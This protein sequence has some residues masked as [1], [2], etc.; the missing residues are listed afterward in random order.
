MNNPLK[1][2]V[3]S[4]YYSPKINPIA[5]KAYSALHPPPYHRPNMEFDY[6]VWLG[7]SSFFSKDGR[8]IGE[9][10]TA[11]ERYKVVIDTEFRPCKFEGTRYG[12]LTN[13]TAS[14]HVLAEIQNAIQL[15]T[16]LRNHYMQRRGLQGERMNLLQSYVFSK[17]GAALTAFHARRRDNRIESGSLAP[18]ETAFFTL[19]VGP[20]MV[21][22]ALMEMGSLIPLDPEPKSAEELYELADSSRSLIS[23]DGTR[24]CA[25]SKKLIIQFADVVWNGSFKGELK[26]PEALRV[27]NSVDDWDGFYAYVYASSK[28]E[29]MIK[30]HQALCSQALILL[31]DHPELC[32]A[33][34]R[35]WVEDA[36][37]HF[38]V[39]LGRGAEGR[40]LL[41][42][43]IRVLVALMDE[44][45]APQIRSELQAAGLI[46]ADGS[47]LDRAQAV[48]AGPRQTAARVLARSGE[49]L[50][51]HCQQELSAVHAA[52]NRFQDSQISLSDL[53]Q[54]CNGPQVEPLMAALRA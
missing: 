1:S 37:S 3:K 35:E 27:F 52:L 8:Q 51:P 10:N 14:R 53:Y 34:E 54:R 23:N 33:Q 12:L 40:E 26:S 13:I 18:L 41:N 29:L 31:H 4:A 32:S 45:D 21:V 20:F 42:N 50:Y 39:S 24:G 49:V 22:R 7:I 5:V 9:A 15:A 17:M 47:G 36:L 44:H 30:L 46:A 16:L 43:M 25:G 6:D 28:L 38:T 11:P 2:L 48:A 19:G